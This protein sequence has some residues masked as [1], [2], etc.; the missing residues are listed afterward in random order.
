MHLKRG[1]FITL[2]GPEG[3]GKSTH[4]RLLFNYLRRKGCKCVLT[5]EPGGTFLGERI[6]KI[7]LDPATK[8]MS[9]VCETLLFEASRAAL[10]E[11][12]II[13]SILKGLIVICDRFS[14][15]TFVYQGLAG[16]QDLKTL[17]TI[18]EYSTRDIK[19]D[20]TILLDIEAEEGLRRAR[21]ARDGKPFRWDRMERKSLAYHKAV[22]KGYLKLA[23][24]EKKR[25]K[26]IKTQDD[27]SKTQELIRREVLRIL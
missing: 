5:H 2:E 27:I 26:A 19:P 8:G 20:L 25:I 16:K 15:A 7:L 13:P 23:G 17:K 6:R 9:A 22:R 11:K 21:K 10:V 18:N 1:K 12:I 14:D 3:C 24:R 4:A